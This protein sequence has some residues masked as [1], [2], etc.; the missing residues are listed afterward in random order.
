MKTHQCK[1]HT[2]T[3]HVGLALFVA[4]VQQVVLIFSPA[5]ALEAEP[6]CGLECKYLTSDEYKNM[7]WTS[8]AEIPGE[9]LPL[10][11]DIF[12]YSKSKKKPFPFEFVLFS[13]SGSDH[14]A[15]GPLRSKEVLC[16]LPPD[17]FSVFVAHV[18]VCCSR[19]V[20]LRSLL[21]S[22]SSCSHG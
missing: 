8:F 12:I 6:S 5:A 18:L 7:L 13:R 21:F 9:S 20:R 11:Q 4:N 22:D 10:S 2:H 15:A 3:L 19:E 14:C 1:L 17:D 16:V